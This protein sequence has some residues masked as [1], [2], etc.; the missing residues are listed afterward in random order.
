MY[1]FVSNTFKDFDTVRK[2]T[3]NILEIIL[4]MFP[5]ADILKK[6]YL[7]RLYAYILKGLE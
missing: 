3:S 1:T 2:I 4:Q 7:S 6:V 5:S